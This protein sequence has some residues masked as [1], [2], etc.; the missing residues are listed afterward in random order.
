MP[1]PFPVPQYSIPGGSDAGVTQA[2][3]TAFYG[4][5]LGDRIRKK[6][7]PTVRRLGMGRLV[8]QTL[9]TMENH[10]GVNQGNRVSVPVNYW[11][12]SL[13]GLTG[14]PDNEDPE[15]F[16][17]YG[18]DFNADL[19]GTAGTVRKYRD[20]A[21]LEHDKS[22]PIGTRR[23]DY[24]EVTLREYGRGYDHKKFDDMFLTQSQVPQIFVDL[25]FNAGYAIDAQAYQV[26]KD[27]YVVAR[28][29]AGT[30]DPVF[31]YRV[32]GG[33]GGT[34]IK[35]R[36]GGTGT[37][38]NEG[39]TMKA[40]NGLL[41][42]DDLMFFVTKMKEALIP[43]FPDG[44]YV[45]I[46]K[47]GFFNGLRKDNDWINVQLYANSGANIINFE[48]GMIHGVRCVEM[49]ELIQPGVGYLIAPNVGV[50]SWALPI[51]LLVEDDW[52]QDFG[53]FS[54]YAWHCGNGVAPA[55]R[56]FHAD[57]RHETITEANRF[58]ETKFDPTTNLKLYELPGHCI[59][60]F[61]GAIPAD[62]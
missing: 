49:N 30:A 41:T 17:Y 21:G 42:A 18:K 55:F 14:S 23:L 53:R 31:G 58:N 19:S 25:A 26:F 61:T 16:H 38:K 12:R 39:T 51:Q 22:I 24:F 46:G 59:K 33:Y 1:N 52:R 11:D 43:T 6:W 62:G 34:N 56:D 32:G 2:Q 10:F 40:G 27:S 13:M 35:E 47:T 7:E 9:L 45:L 28:T 3:M 20:F 4:H 44:S 15:G 8:F 37:N 57:G 48:I 5:T 50:V 29:S 60:I 54:K 36:I